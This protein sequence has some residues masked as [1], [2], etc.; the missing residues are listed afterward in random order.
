MSSET[1]DEL[2]EAIDKVRFL[3]NRQWMESG[4]EVQ[5]L[6]DEIEQLRAGL[7]C[8]SEGD[9]PESSQWLAD[10]ILAG[11]FV[12]TK[13]SGHTY[14]EKC[15]FCDTQIEVPAPMQYAVI[16]APCRDAVY[17]R[18]ADDMAK[19]YLESETE[20]MRDRESVTEKN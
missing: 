14:T 18:M 20:H 4:N 8:I 10:E 3:S 11:R 2:L 17:Q 12:T 16:C 9:R 15:M 7:K 1:H 6:R 5:A 19:E 13:G